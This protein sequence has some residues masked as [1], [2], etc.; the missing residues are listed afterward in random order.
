MITKEIIGKNDHLY[1]ALFADITSSIDKVTVNTLEE[2]FMN[3]EQIAAYVSD[4]PNKSYYL[5]L[6][7]D[8]DMFVI[9]ANTRAINVPANYR[10][11][12]I[13]VVGDAF[14]ETL[15]F[16]IDRY[17]DLQDLN[18]ANIRIYWQLPDSKDLGYSNPVLVDVNSEAR[19]LIFGWAIPE[20]LTEKSGELKFAISFYIDDNIAYEFNTLAQSV[21]I[22]KTLSHETTK[23][24]ETELS[25][26]ISRLRNTT[27]IGKIFVSRPIY[28]IISPDF[29]NVQ[30][31]G[32]AGA[33]II[34]SAYSNTNGSEIEYV[35]YRNGNKVNDISPVIVYNKTSDT[36]INQD[37]IYY[38]ENG[39][40]QIELDENSMSNYYEK[41][42]KFIV[43]SVGSYQCKAIAKYNVED[44]QG[45]AITNS[46]APQYTSLWIW[47]S[48]TPI[49]SEEIKLKAVNDDI[50][51]DEDKRPVQ[52]TLTIPEG[53]GQQ[54]AALWTINLYE[55]E[56][57]NPIA[58]NLSTVED[59]S[60]VKINEPGNYYVK[61]KKTLNNITT[62]EIESNHLVVQNAATE[63]K[64]ELGENQASLVPV[65]STVTFSLTNGK[66]EHTYIYV[67][68]K[69]TNGGWKAIEKTNEMKFVDST[70]F[71][72]TFKQPGKYRLIVEATYGQ[73]IKITQ[74]TNSEPV[75]IYTIGE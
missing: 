10:N 43:N 7:A 9:N 38:N 74:E 50:V 2:Y 53:K 46:S 41:C 48:P 56:E 40:V 25:T 35:L 32:D 26:I 4:Y 34:V 37:K 15:W 39:E 67:I 24:D 42:A 65:G 55:K 1:D 5:R 60:D 45:N 18:L 31:F 21:K 3:I 69:Y 73:S 44:D 51:L 11:Y 22:N 52:F 47:E 28:S 62:G 17:Y 49:T 63:V 71:L 58:S 13:A 16:K 20:M 19:Q 64:V 59:L 57:E 61:V 54:A 23:V 6:P 8:E 12:G 70:E 14:A 30:A 72:Y 66:N 29:N 75:E 36:K 68:E 27:E 33:E